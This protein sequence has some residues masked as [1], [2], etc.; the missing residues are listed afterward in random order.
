MGGIVIILATLVGYFAANLLTS[1]SISA[2]ALLLLFLFTG[3][4]VVGFLDD[5]IKIVKQRSLGLRSA[6]KMIGQTVIALVFGILALS[7][8]LEDENHRRPASHHIS[9]LK[10]IG[11]ELPDRAGAAADLVRA[12]PASATPSTSPTASTAS[13]RARA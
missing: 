3:L 8:W 4:G 11:W 6:A 2:S 12:S 9:F 10:D 1:G 7:P 5:F 13:R